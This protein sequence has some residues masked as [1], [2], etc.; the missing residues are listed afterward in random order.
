MNSPEFS[1]FDKNCMQRAL[2]LA[3]Q[4]RYGTS[5]NPRVGCVIVIEDQIVAEGYHL[6]KGGAHAEVN[7]LSQVSGLDLSKATVYVTLEPCSHFGSTPPCALAL[8]NKHVKTVIAAMADPNPLVAGQGFE[9]LKNAQI[10]TKYGL[11]EAQAREINKGFLSRIERGIP[12]CILKM[13]ISIDGKTALRNGQSQWIT[14]EISRLDVQESRA[15]ACAILTG[16]GTV[17]KDNPHLN[18]RSIN[19]PRQPI[20]I[21]LDSELNIPLNSNVISDSNSPTWIVTLNHDSPKLDTLIQYSH[22]KIIHATEK[23]HRINLSALMTVLA[24]S[25]IGELYI[26]CGAT[27]AGAL[28]KEN[29]I[30]EIHLYQ[31]PIILGH[32]AKNAFIFEE[33]T[34]LSQVQHWHIDSS[35]YLGGDIKLILRQ[36]LR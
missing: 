32:H 11:F 3:W 12:Y 35:K 29:L 5:P 34:D 33:V 15:Q 19:T 21:I 25:E 9:L 4:G 23:N 24:K 36:K 7:A 26:E 28:V 27:L 6:I 14:S 1:E 30:D 20:R 10:E 2:S 17:I 18:V 16:I 8:I 31:A 13:G 22:I